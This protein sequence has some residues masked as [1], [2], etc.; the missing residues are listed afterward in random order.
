[1]LLSAYPALAADQQKVTG[2][3]LKPE[4]V[5][6]IQGISQNLLTAKHSET[7][8]PE[9]QQLRQQV[10]ELR[11]S[12]RK[13]DTSTRTTVPAGAIT[14]I[15]KNVIKDQAQPTDKKRE[16]RLTHEKLE[17][18]VHAAL[19]RV[20]KQRTNVENLDRDDLKEQH[21]SPLRRVAAKV[22]ELEDVLEQAMTGQPEERAEKLEKLQQRLTVSG[23]NEQSAREP[24]TPTISTI[25]R[26]RE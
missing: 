7:P 17:Q 18:D 12:V 23:N 25:V 16:H 13:L 9:L 5:Q 2:E 20:R 10:D 21:K 15:D 8:A 6:E 19:K 22:K 11:T 4:T 24:G 1:V 14:I 26:H 3:V